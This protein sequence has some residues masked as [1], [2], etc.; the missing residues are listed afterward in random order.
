MA[1]SDYD[2]GEEVLRLTSTLFMF[3]DVDTVL[4]NQSINLFFTPAPCASGSSH[5]GG[6]FP[7]LYVC[8]ILP[9]FV[10]YSCMFGGRPHQML[11]S[12]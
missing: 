12:H 8:S 3:S 9:L 10:S 5:P 4:N 7:I 6:I 2:D 11:N 1:P